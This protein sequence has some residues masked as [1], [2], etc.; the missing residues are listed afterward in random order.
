MLI[1]VYWQSYDMYMNK[2][3]HKHLLR[4]TNEQIAL[5]THNYDEPIT[6]HYGEDIIS[7]DNR[8]FH[9]IPRISLQAR[10]PLKGYRK[11]KLGYTLIKNGL[12]YASMYCD[13]LSLGRKRLFERSL[14]VHVF[15]FQ[16]EV[17]CVY[18]VYRKGNSS[19]FFVVY[20]QLQRCVGIIER[21]AYI[22]GF[23]RSRSVIHLEDEN[24]I[25][26]LMVV[27]MLEV[28]G[29]RTDGDRI[30]DSSA[31][32]IR[33]GEEEAAMF[34]EDFYNRTH[35]DFEKLPADLEKELF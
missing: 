21:H 28:L 22:Q 2:I 34:D 9:W 20:D 35:S 30:Y 17:L 11:K 14:E 1:D 10:Y 25:E 31:P 23:N 15:Q 6:L 7:Y 12:P 27:N 5:V 33:F 26:K 18:T 4:G 24:Y 3:D 8:E 32:T 29:Y 19:M 13:S 16:D